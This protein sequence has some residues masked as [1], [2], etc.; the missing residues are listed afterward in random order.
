MSEKGRFYD[1]LLALTKHLVSIPSVSPT[2]GEINIAD[3]IEKNIR[4][5]PYFSQHPDYVITR[6]L[7][8]DPLGRKNVFALL[9][10]TGER[11]DTIVCHG[12][13]D[14]VNVD[15]FGPLKPYAF[16]CSELAAH[17]SSTHL[18][19]DVRHDLEDGNWLFGRGACDMKSGDAVFLILLRFL[20]QPENR[21]SGNL[22]FLFTCDEECENTGMVE[23]VPVIEELCQKFQLHPVL[24][25]N[26]DYVGPLYQDDPHRYVYTGTV[27]KI[28]ASFYILGIETHVGRIYEGISAS[29]IAA[30]LIDAVDTNPGLCDEYDGEFCQ[31]PALLKMKDLKTEY[32]V[33]TSQAAFIYFNYL[34]HD[35]E[36]SDILEELKQIAV[37]ELH[38]YLSDQEIKFQTFCRRT[39][40]IYIPSDAVPHVYTFEE[41]CALCR[42]RGMN[43]DSRI[44]EIAEKDLS[45]GMDKRDISQHIVE[46]LC[47]EAHLFGPAVI[48]FL[49]PPYCPHNTLHKEIPAEDSL[50]Q[51]II[52]VAEKTGLEW[53]EKFQV[54]HF[55]PYL[56]DSSYVKIDDSYP[57]MEKT[58]SNFPAMDTL[59]PLPL[60]TIK[61]L[62]I[63]A[64]NMG[65]YGRD[66][67]TWTE[68]L[69][70]PYSFNV[71]PELLLNTF[72]HFLK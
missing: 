11:H 28:L 57:S 2:A 58:L 13:M 47:D 19:N 14:T 7:P 16:S 38:N 5:I 44:R 54:R 29:A 3:E 63:P 64:V 68:R 21:L 60:Q 35:R 31:P 26:N 46:I 36:I 56:S 30:R 18:P 34:I 43:P 40:E 37:H 6:T 51:Q 20:S 72:R 48:L 39:G 49:S 71:L 41:L 23:A 10:G 67:H 4:A 27:G 70:M 25:V 62:S 45:A 59:Y 9:K 53:N 22:L 50:R 24:A 42:K 33:Q 15:D 32:N 17:L 1:D 66:C 69:Y 8:N 55:F 65:V 61:K 12:H 52:E